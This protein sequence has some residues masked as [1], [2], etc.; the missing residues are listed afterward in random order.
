[1]DNKIIPWD[2]FSKLTIICFLGLQII[3]W[4]LFPQF[5]DIYYHLLTAWGFIQAGGYT[6]WDFWQFAPVGRMHIY[7]PLFHFILVFFMKLGID[8]LILAKS[9]EAIL[10]IIFLIVLWQFVQKNY[11]SS[12]AFFSLISLNSSFSFYLSLMNFLPATLAMIL[13]ILALDQFF[14]KQILRTTTLLTL[15]FYTHI[16]VAYFFI[17]GIILYGIFNKSLRRMSFLIAF[18]SFLLS[19]PV[20]FKQISALRL[21][22]ISHIPI[23]FFCEFKT[24]DYILGISGLFIS[25][26]RNERF[27]LFLSLFFASFIFIY[28]PSR[29]ISAQG[30]L[31]IIFLSAVTLDELFNKIRFKIAYTRYA[32]FLLLGLLIFVSPTILMEESQETCKMKY[33]LYIY[34][35][36][37]INMI[38]PNRN[39]RVT[40][41]NILPSRESLATAELIKQHSFNDDIIFSDLH[42]VGVGLASISGRATAN[43]L[44]PELCSVSGFDPLSVSKIYIASKDIKQSFLEAIANNYKLLKIGENKLFII[45]KNPQ[46]PFKSQIKKA[47]VSFRV[48]W[49]IVFVI[50]IFFSQAK[51]IESYIKKYL[52]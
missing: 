23:R 31:P 14:Q 13:G 38:F 48:I 29:L 51:R 49:F 26:R 22:S 47:S 4:P 44:L 33:S 50:G 32:F 30:Y 2:F 25:F 6:G 52:T 5:M 15:C 37:L 17:L 45:Y 46:C 27:N 36:S 35:S 28:Y 39:K 7:P 11:S 19:L 16:G 10:P 42:H 34:D 43:A 1:M 40:A 9:L 18:G 20:L 41:I 3:R 24:V 21:I 8:R 12:L